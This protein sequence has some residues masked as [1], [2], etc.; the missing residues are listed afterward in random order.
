MNATLSILL[1]E[2]DCRHRMRLAAAAG[3]YLLLRSLERR[4]PRQAAHAR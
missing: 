2:Q 4:G 3:A 1:V